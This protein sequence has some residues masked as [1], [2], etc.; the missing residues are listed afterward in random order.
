MPAE[1]LY[2]TLPQNAFTFCSYARE[3]NDIFEQL[4]A[5]VKGFDYAGVHTNV[6][7]PATH[8]LRALALT[9]GHTIGSH[10]TGSRRQRGAPFAPNLVCVCVS[11][12]TSRSRTRPCSPPYTRVRVV[13]GR[14]LD[15]H[16]RRPTSRCWR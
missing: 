15:S 14:A 7:A 1:P 16:R 12:V 6:R 2:L 5:A 10:A 8:S 3:L 4:I 13:R 11:P 9:R